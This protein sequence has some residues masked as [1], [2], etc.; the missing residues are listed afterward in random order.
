MFAKSITANNEWPEKLADKTASGEPVLFVDQSSETL[1]AGAL[2][3]MSKHFGER[4][5]YQVVPKPRTNLGCRV[6]MIGE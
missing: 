5:S 3:K 6:E 1:H 2:W 4:Y